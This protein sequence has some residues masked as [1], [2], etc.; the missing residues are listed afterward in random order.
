MGAQEAGAASDQY[1]LFEMHEI[2]PERSFLAKLWLSLGHITAK[3]SVDYVIIIVGGS[4]RLIFG[5]IDQ[6]C[7]SAVSGRRRSIVLTLDGY[8]AIDQSATSV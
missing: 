8:A 4:A 1:T 6:E 7:L 2:T 3:R 5:R